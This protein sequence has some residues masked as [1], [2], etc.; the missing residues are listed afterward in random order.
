MCCM[1]NYAYFAHGILQQYTY[2]YNVQYS[3]IHIQLC[4]YMYDESITKRW[5]FYWCKRCLYN[6]YS[7]RHT[8]MYDGTNW[9]PQWMASHVWMRQAVTNDVKKSCTKISGIL[10]K[11]CYDEKHSAVLS[12]PSYNFPLNTFYRSPF[13]LFPLSTLPA[14]RF[15][16]FFLS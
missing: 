16:I 1:C 4:R 11:R 12:L 13:F 3:N 7:I 9:I 15:N 10:E 2:I 5:K 14:A 6:T 8:G